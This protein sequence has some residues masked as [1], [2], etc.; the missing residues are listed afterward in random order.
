MALPPTSA[1]HHPPWLLYGIVTLLLLANTINIAADIG[2]MGAASKLL[3]RRPR[4]L[5]RSWLRRCICGATDLRA[6]PALLAHPEGAYAGPPRLRDY[7]VRG[8]NPMGRGCLRDRVPLD[9][10]RIGIRRS[11]GSGLRHDDHA[12]STRAA[13]SFCA[14][15][16]AAPPMSGLY[17]LGEPFA[18]PAAT[19]R[20]LLVVRHRMVRHHYQP[21]TL[22]EVRKCLPSLRF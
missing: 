10:V 20:T 5:V 18:R 8:Q 9:L 19:A 21:S 7:P 12:G 14:E 3:D 17:A 6:V 4:S 15:R 16:Q 11:G 1:K 13:G 2:A 22:L